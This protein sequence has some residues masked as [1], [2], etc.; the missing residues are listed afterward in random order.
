MAG[1][2]ALRLGGHSRTQAAG[3][4]WGNEWPFGPEEPLINS[5]AFKSDSH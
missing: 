5:W 2:L 1:P 4:G 3:L